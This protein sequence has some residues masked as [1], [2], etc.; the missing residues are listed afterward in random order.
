MTSQLRHNYQVSQ[1][2]QGTDDVTSLHF[3]QPGQFSERLWSP[4]YYYLLPKA[5]ET[6]L[7]LLT[8]TLDANLSN[9]QTNELTSYSNG[10][11]KDR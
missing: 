5:G 7:S 2:V 3:F 6:D 11:E 1:A 8:L 4:S 10:L 9:K